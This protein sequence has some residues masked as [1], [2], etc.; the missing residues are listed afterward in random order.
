MHVVEVFLNS[1]TAN[2]LTA[3]SDK[4]KQIDCSKFQ[5]SVFTSDNEE[6]VENL[7]QLALI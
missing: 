2:L 6:L 1:S 5:P 7:T 4:A 3:T